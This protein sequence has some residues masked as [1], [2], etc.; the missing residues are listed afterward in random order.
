MH[1]CQMF[2]TVT[3]QY[4][5][6]GGVNSMAQGLVGLQAEGAQDVEVVRGGVLPAQGLGG[7]DGEQLVRAVEGLGQDAR[8]GG[9]AAWRRSSPMA[10]ICSAIDRVGGEGGRPGRVEGGDGEL[11]S[12]PRSARSAMYWRT[13][14]AEASSGIG[15]QV[16]PSSSVG[17][18]LVGR[19]HE[20]EPAV[21]VEHRSESDT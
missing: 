6:P 13:T 17:V 18:R 10:V 20:C 2:S 4:R 12:A 5:V 1:S 9:S 7:L 16:A 11:G 8:G 21:G 14:M 15:T 19:Q 3:F